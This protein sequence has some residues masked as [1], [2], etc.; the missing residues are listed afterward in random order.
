MKSMWLLKEG[1]GGGGQVKSNSKLGNLSPIF[2]LA[3]EF[4]VHPL[5]LKRLTLR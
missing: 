3:E 4:I 2:A 5:H 1:G